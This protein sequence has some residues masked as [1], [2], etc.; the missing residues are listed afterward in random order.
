MKSK[1]QTYHFHLIGVFIGYLIYW[2]DSRPNWD[3]TGIT[4]SLLLISSLVLG[5]LISRKPWFLALAIGIWIPLNDLIANFH[6][7]SVLA[8]MIS[9]I[10]SYIG[11]VAQSKFRHKS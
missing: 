1:I 6:F 3:D 5:F 9:F 7:D 2:I 8:L 4:A 11:Y 10:G